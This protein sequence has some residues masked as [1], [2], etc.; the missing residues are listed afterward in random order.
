MKLFLKQLLFCLLFLVVYSANGQTIPHL[1]GRTY[2]PFEKHIWAVFDKIKAQNRYVGTVSAA[3]LS[4]ELPM[5]IVRR[6]GNVDYVLAIDS[7][8]RKGGVWVFSA[9]MAVKLPKTGDNS[10]IAFAARNIVFNPQGIGGASSSVLSATRLELV[11]TNTI[12]LS[13]DLSVEFSKTNGVSNNYIEFDCNGYK[14]ISLEGKFKFSEGLLIPAVVPTTGSGDVEPVPVVPPANAALA[15]NSPK[16]TAT[17]RIMI[18]DLSNVLVMASITPF[19][20]KGLKDFIFEVQEASL[21]MSDL[22]NP[23]GFAFPVGYNG[24]TGADAPLWQGFHLKLLRITFLGVKSTNTKPPVSIVA[25]NVLIDDTGVSGLFEATG[26]ILSIGDGSAG[27]WAVSIDYLRVKLVQNNLMGA[28]MEGKLKV[29]FLGENPMSYEATMDR[30]NGDVTYTF[31][32]K[33]DSAETYQMPIGLTAKMRAGTSVTVTRANGT[34]TARA[35]LTGLLSSSQANSSFSGIA[36][37][38]VIVT[39]ASPYVTGGTFSLVSTTAPKCRGFGISLT[40]I[41]LFTVNPTQSKFTVRA[42]VNFTDSGSGGTAISAA[43]TIDFFVNTATMSEAGL[44]RRTW[45]LDRITVN[46]IAIS[47]HTNSFSLDGTIA[48]YD[49]DP[50]YGNGFKG[51]ITL[52]IKDYAFG[53]TIYFGTKAISATDSNTFRYFG[54]VAFGKGFNLAC[55]APFFITGIMG[56]FAYK[57]RNGSF[58]PDYSLLNAPGAAVSGIGYESNTTSA[59]INFIPDAS[60]GILFRAGINFKIGPMAAKDAPATG[61]AMLEVAFSSSGSLN[62]I[63]F[64]GAVYFMND[65]EAMDTRQKGETADV[66]QKN[67]GTLAIVYD[68]TNKCFHAVIE[69]FLNMDVIKGAGPNGKLGQIVIHIDPN[70]WYI[71]LGKSTDMLGATIYKMASVHAYFMIGTVVEGMPLL[72]VA[73]RNALGAPPADPRGN[74]SAALQYG[75]GFA[76]GVHLGASFGGDFWIFYAKLNI[77]AGLDVLILNLPSSMSCAG[78]SGTPGIDGWFAQGQIYVFIGGSVGIKAR[79]RRI[80]IASMS[81]AMLLQFKGPNPTWFAGRLNGSYSVLCGLISGSFRFD[82]EMGEKCTLIS[83]D[84]NASEISVT[85]IESMKPDANATAVSVFALP[86]VSFNL[87]VDVAFKMEDMNG[88][89]TDYRASVMEFSCKNAGQTVLGT[90][91]WSSN[92]K[93]YSFKSSEVLPPNATL[94]L[95][96]VIKWE[97][98]QGGNWINLTRANGTLET[99]MKESTFTTGPAPDDIYGNVKNAYPVKN[100]YNLYKSE[101][102]SGFANLD[103]GQ[104]YLFETTD[105]QGKNWRFEARFKEIS[106][107]APALITGLNYDAGAK[108]VNFGLPTNLT[109]NKIYK[110]MLVKIPVN[111]PTTANNTQTN[112]TTSVSDG[113]VTEI[114]TNQLQNT[115]STGE[116]IMYEL[117]FRTSNYPTF[118][119]KMATYGNGSDYDFIMGNGAFYLYKDYQSTNETLDDLEIDP[120]AQDFGTLPPLVSLEAVATQSWLTSFHQPVIYDTYPQAANVTLS[121]NPATLGLIPLKGVYFHRILASPYSL[122]LQDINAGVANAK[123]GAVRINYLVPFFVKFDADELRGKAVASYLNGGGGGA[124]QNLIAYLYRQITPGNYGVTLKYTLPDGTVTSIIPLNIVAR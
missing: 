116:K 76:F 67:Y 120:Y 122:N 123:P 70:N 45:Q 68:H 110:M 72:P 6:I 73:V 33:L 34:T 28:G 108:K 85:I 37:Q 86:Q 117:H 87:P 113:S 74:Q 77:M 3:T 71:Y 75:R 30:V 91:L 52:G 57:M 44:Q 64:Q 5:G 1:S 112:V 25:S 88:V 35:V 84:P 119:A 36:F 103:R 96:I 39:S 22:I 94:N 53:A 40:Q 50:V 97:K 79:G 51:G 100:Q 12:T 80:D 2:N 102:P 24:Y 55:P 46:N 99:E 89:A 66:S 8:S 81:I 104:A 29:P 111:A 95:R 20:V 27:G 90:Y 92:K 83:N 118:T 93:V 47:C 41:G 26:N 61:D 101:A 14:S 109:S 11:S 31:G 114:A 69:G 23:A 58:N 62:Y 42:G 38:N 43:A 56:G 107:S 78:R 59:N 9:Y 98:L 15:T 63:R 7:A 32:V 21:D 82:F 4:N 106:S 115:L 17:F 54:V 124:I 65:E 49:N 18:A 121:R 60:K 10:L 16:V 19:K 105:T 13:D 48:V